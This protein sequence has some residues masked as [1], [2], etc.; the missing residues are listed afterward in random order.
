[1]PAILDRAGLDARRSR[2]ATD[3]E[4]NGVV[5]RSRQTIRDASTGAQALFREIAGQG[6]HKTLGRGF[7]IVRDADGKTLTSAGS[8]AS[9]E[10]IEVAFKDGKVDATV[11]DVKLGTSDEVLGQLDSGGK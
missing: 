1:M 6:P 11:R 7:A 10:T 5:D 8:A 2:A 3:S 4:F 9:A